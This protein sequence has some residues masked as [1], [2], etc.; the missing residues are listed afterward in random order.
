MMRSL[1][2]QSLMEKR[3]KS[4]LARRFAE[5]IERKCRDLDNPPAFAEAGEGN[6]VNI[7]LD[8]H[9][10]PDLDGVVIRTDQYLL[11]YRIEQAAAYVEGISGHEIHSPEPLPVG[12]SKSDVTTV[13]FRANH[14]VRT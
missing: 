7:Y 2:M 8:Y 13:R 9:K 5:E 11:R 6:R 1:M 14:S 4:A 10:H 12:R 3:E